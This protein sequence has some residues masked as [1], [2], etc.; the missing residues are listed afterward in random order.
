MGQD[1]SAV[2]ED[3]DMYGT[4]IRAGLRHGDDARCGE[5]TAER[6]HQEAAAIHYSIT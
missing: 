3:T 5:S 4:A 1:S 2:T 6:D